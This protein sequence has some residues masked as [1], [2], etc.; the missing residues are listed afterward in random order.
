[1]SSWTNGSTRRASRNGA[2]TAWARAR[3]AS[4]RRLNGRSHLRGARRDHPRV[5]A[6][7]R[8]DKPVHLQYF[9]SCAKRHMGDYSARRP[10]LLQAMTGNIACAGGCQT[11]A[12]LPTPGRV[13]APRADFG[14]DPALPGAGAVQ[15]Q[16]PY[17]DS[18]LSEGLLGRPHGA[19]ASSVIASA[20][21]TTIAR[22]R[23][24]R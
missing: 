14:R 2:P 21:R 10:M 13:P 23:T 12:C 9:Y 1:M 4:R 17:R 18:R 16:L 20:R 6:P 5:R 22:C 24:S 15:Q 7:L 3:T 11:G 8:H 19:R